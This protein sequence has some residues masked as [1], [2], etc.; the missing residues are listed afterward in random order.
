MKKVINDCSGNTNC[1]STLIKLID[2]KKF[3]AAF[4]IDSVKG[5]F[6]LCESSWSKSNHSSAKTIF[7]Q[8][9]EGIHGAIQQLMRKQHKLMLQNN[10]IIV[11]QYL[12]MK[13]IEQS[14]TIATNLRDIFLYEASKVLCVKGYKLIKKNYMNAS[15]VIHK[16]LVDQSICF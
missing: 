4:V 13:V 7:S 11:K 10:K 12:E 2:L 5:N 9:L 8:F 16:V 14:H 15:L 6:G 3:L 1:V